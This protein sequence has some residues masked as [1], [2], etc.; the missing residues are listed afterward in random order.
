M[1]RP[2][3][4]DSPVRSKTRL[5]REHMTDRPGSLSAPRE[6]IAFTIFTI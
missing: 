2:I 1:A 5:N 6:R 4:W 3:H